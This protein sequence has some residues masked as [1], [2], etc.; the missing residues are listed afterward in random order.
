MIQRIQS[1]YL[2]LTC[3]LMV[4]AIFSPLLLIDVSGVFVKYTS[5]GAFSERIIYHTWGIVSIAGICALLPLVNIFLYKKRKNQ[6]KIANIT[7]LLI[8]LF[9]ITIGVYYCSMS[10]KFEVSLDNVQYGIFLPLIALI[11]NILATCKIKKDHNL[12]KSLDRI[13]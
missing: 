2:L 10:A 8:V 11:A 7:S 9:Y 13:R 6:I 5:F 3:A 1:V 4:A 12:I